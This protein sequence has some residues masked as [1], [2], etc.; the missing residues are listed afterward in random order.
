MSRARWF[1]GIAAALCL[2]VL[3][4]FQP[5]WA[6]EN[7]EDLA[8][9]VEQ[10]EKEIEKLSARDD[11]YNYLTEE[12]KAYREFV[13]KQWGWF[14]TAFLGALPIVL[15][16]VGGFLVFFGIRSKKDIEEK[17]QRNIEENAK[18]VEKKIKGTIQ[19][20]IEEEAK[21]EFHNVMKSEVIKLQ[22]RIHDLEE[23]TDREFWFRNSKIV[24]LDRGSIKDIFSSSPFD[25][26][27]SINYESLPSKNLS[28]LLAQGQVDILVYEYDMES[29]DQKDPYIEDVL[30]ELMKYSSPAIPIVIYTAGKQLNNNEIQ[31]LLEQHKFYTFAN[32]S[33]TLV[34]NTR[35]LTYAYYSHNE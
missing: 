27:I 26:K 15:A 14:L 33:M 9:R 8:E 17:A 24:V 20:R 2:A 16:I 4:S 18:E 12:T 7:E 23:I 19:E 21:R 35:N 29:E 1:G 6:Q 28:Q 3:F 31:E 34:T 10:L 11:N 5:T 13:E 30:N 25:G 32:N 22:G